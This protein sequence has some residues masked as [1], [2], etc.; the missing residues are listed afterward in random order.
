MIKLTIMSNKE[1]PSVSINQAKIL[2][3]MN[4]ENKS[5][6][7]V[8]DF[9]TDAE[10]FESLA[11][12]IDDL[13]ENSFITEGKWHKESRTTQRRRDNVIKCYLTEKGLAEI[14]KVSGA[15]L[16]SKGDFDAEVWSDDH[17]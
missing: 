1:Q 6:F 15:F 4:N 14:D 3:K 9:G 13:A 5:S 2:Y 16:H 17:N 10:S 12:A 7:N 8:G 11:E